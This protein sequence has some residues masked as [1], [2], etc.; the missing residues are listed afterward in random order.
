MYISLISSRICSINDWNSDGVVTG[1]WVGV[2]VSVGVLVTEGVFVGVSW[3]ARRQ[4]WVAHIKKNGH[5]KYLGGF[6]I[7]QDAARAYD[8]AARVLHG[9]FANLNFPEEANHRDTEVEDPPRRDT[10][11]SGSDTH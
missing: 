11:K 7:E 8:A 5:P 4:I 2:L 10:E 9:P 3:D 6:P 1:V